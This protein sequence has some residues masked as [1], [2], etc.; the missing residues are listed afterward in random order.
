MTAEK[1]S[2]TAPVQPMVS[3]DLDQT[4]GAGALLDLKPGTAWLLYCD[5]GPGGPCG[6]SMRTTCPHSYLMTWPNEDAMRRDLQDAKWR[7]KKHTLMWGVVD[8]YT[9]GGVFRVIN[10]SG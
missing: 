10:H 1:A 6:Q 7:N 9:T 4:Y 2:A 8:E 3:R 5:N